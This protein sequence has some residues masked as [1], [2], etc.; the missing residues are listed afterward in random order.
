MK[1]LSFGEKGEFDCYRVDEL[2]AAKIAKFQGKPV[3]L[4]RECTECGDLLFG[5]SL[6]PNL[7]VKCV[8]GQHNSRP[9]VWV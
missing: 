1:V 5:E 2:E 9:G 6:D 3:M 4:A 7:Q 8:R